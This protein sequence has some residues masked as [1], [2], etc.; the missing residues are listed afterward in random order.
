MK[1][2]DMNV[3]FSSKSD[4]WSTPQWLFD[5]L[6]KQYDFTLDPAS[7]GVNNKCTKHYTAKENG[8][9]QSWSRET[10][11]INPPYSNTYAWV[12]KAYHEAFSG[13]TSVLLVPARMDSKWFH[14][15]CLD[16]IVCKSLTF[17]RSRLKFGDSK[18]SAPFPS[19]IIEFGPQTLVIQQP[20]LKSMSNK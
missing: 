17:I 19:M 12:S 4:E 11:F 8:L 14:E 7:D 16:P 6:N 13:T 20:I 5:K 10:V 3:L 9:E 18:N 15:F 1:K 2:S